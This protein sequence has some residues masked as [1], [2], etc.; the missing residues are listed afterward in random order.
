MKKPNKMLTIADMLFTLICLVTV[1]C[2][3]MQ[4]PYRI[5]VTVCLALLA[6]SVLIFMKKGI[7]SEVEFIDS[8]T[9]LLENENHF[10]S[11]FDYT[12]SGMAL[13]SRNG[14]FLK[15][16]HSLCQILGY[17]EE[18]LMARSIRKIMNRE[19]FSD[20]LGKIREMMHGEIKNFQSV[21]RFYNKQN[22]VVWIGS[23]I[24]FVKDNDNKPLYFVGQFQTALAKNSVNDLLQSMAY[25]DSLT[26]LSNRSFLDQHLGSL[27]SGDK[28]TKKSFAILLLDLDGLKNVNDSMGH[29][30]GDAL[31]K[32]VAIRLR[33]SVRE[34]D[35]IARIGGD[36]FA[37][38]IKNTTK[39]E[40]IA[41]IA[42]KIL[43]NLLK[44]M[45][46]DNHEVYMTASI[47]I[48]LYPNDGEDIETLIKNAD[49]ALYNAKQNKGNNYQFSLPNITEQAQ[50]KAKQHSLLSN[51]MAKN[52]LQLHYQP[53]IS[54]Q[55]NHVTSVEALIRWQSDQ[56]GLVMPDTII[57]LAEES[58]LIFPL[59]EWI[60]RTACKQVKEWQDKGNPDLKLSINISA[61]QFKN[62]SFTNSIIRAVKESEIPPQ[63]LILEITESLVMHDHENTL[64]TLRKIKEEGIGI[65]V[66]D[67]GSGFSSF[68]YLTN[69]AIDKIK[70]DRKLIQK[71]TESKSEK[72][73]VSA[74]ISMAKVLGIKTVAE[75][76]E[77]QEQMQILTSEKCDEAQGYYI[78]KPLSIDLMETFLVTH[79]ANQKKL[80]IQEMQNRE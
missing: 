56:Y 72:S 70:I 44:I 46:L 78:A 59:G 16:N 31:L 10:R 33:K 42:Q 24:S 54:L 65:V 17:S 53:C 11:A 67:F 21:N 35:V 23:C 25:T 68:T 47:G 66:D 64:T 4:I 38:A 37:I 77:T 58:G 48:S 8:Y 60:V 30:K 80:E 61:Y 2:W 5:E 74:M 19:D 18:E 27:L 79:A 43:G 71:V 6:V 52:E 7:K 41:Q 62:S 13:L 9:Q 3:Y 29:D 28:Q 55:D 40:V 63:S 36:E 22:E 15:V 26:G 49:L 76:V 50:E 57:P 39:I 51:A 1:A 45:V 34:D 69:Y 73:I 75:G 32:E 20:A 12:A 14:H